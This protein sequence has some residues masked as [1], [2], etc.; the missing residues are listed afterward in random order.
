MKVLRPDRC[1]NTGWNTFLNMCQIRRMK[2]PI[3]PCAHFRKAMRAVPERKLLTAK[4]YPR[5]LVPLDC[6]AL[7]GLEHKT[8]LHIRL[9]LSSPPA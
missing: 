3:F 4:P 7:Q 8:L 2:F 5:L 1:V 9:R 6:I